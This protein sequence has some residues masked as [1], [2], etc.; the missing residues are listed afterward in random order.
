MKSILNYHKKVKSK[1]ILR[2]TAPSVNLQMKYEKAA[3]IRQSYP[4]GWGTGA[5]LYGASISK[6]W[7]ARN[8]PNVPFA[9]ITPVCHN[10]FYFPK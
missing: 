2:R 6:C 8:R 1:L 10:Q 4:A 7:L 5:Q 3:L 9:P